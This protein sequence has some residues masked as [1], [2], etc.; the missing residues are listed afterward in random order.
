MTD[1]DIIGRTLTFPDGRRGKV[2]TCSQLLDIAL[3]AVVDAA[4]EATG[5][6]GIAKPS[7]FQI[8]FPEN[9]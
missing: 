3:I 9:A 6:H 2:V 7:T 4:G 5:R 1:A 8:A